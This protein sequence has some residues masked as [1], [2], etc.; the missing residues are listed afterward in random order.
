LLARDEPEAAELVKLRIFADFSVEE[1]GQLLGLSRATAYRHWTYA[2][3]RL[4]VA[5]ADPEEP[6]P[7]SNKS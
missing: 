2:R 6:E 3:A 1:A 7:T 5:M 4:K